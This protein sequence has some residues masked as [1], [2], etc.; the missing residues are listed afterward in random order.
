[1]LFDDL[2]LYCDSENNRKIVYE[3]LGYKN[4]EEFKFFKNLKKYKNY[5]IEEIESMCCVCTINNSISIISTKEILEY[6][7]K[8]N[9]I[10][11]VVSKC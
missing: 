3:I 2:D 4:I 5:T 1:M 11:K 10:E 8:E 9:L 7:T 6:Y